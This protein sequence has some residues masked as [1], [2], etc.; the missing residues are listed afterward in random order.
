MLQ[1]LRKIFSESFTTCKVWCMSNLRTRHILSTLIGMN[2]WAQIIKSEFV[3]TEDELQL[4]NS[5]SVICKSYR[6]KEIVKVGWLVDQPYL[7]LRKYWINNMVD[8]LLNRKHRL[9]AKIWKQQ[10]KQILV[11]EE[12]PRAIFLSYA[13]LHP[14]QQQPF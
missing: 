5:R 6:I 7:T 9:H 1:L 10:T 3:Y 11:L 14:N 2:L 4:C 12:I 8:T 13:L